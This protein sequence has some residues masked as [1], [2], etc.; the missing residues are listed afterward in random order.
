MQDLAA[1]RRHLERARE[2][3]LA[4]GIAA[5]PAEEIGQVHEG[6]NEP[7]VEPE[8]GPELRFRV[9]RLAEPGVEGRQV[10]VRLGPLRVDQLRLDQLG[11]GGLEARPALG[12][13]GS[14]RPRQGPGRLDPHESPRIPEER[15][16]G[17]G[18]P[19][20]GERGHRRHRRGPDEGI[21]VLQG[22]LDRRER[23]GREGLGQEPALHPHDGVQLVQKPRVDTRHCGQLGGSGSPA[24]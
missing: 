11:E 19:V 9:D 24:Q 4:V 5:L 15:R 7:R 16:G 14:R 3:P 20:G 17:R 1:P 23:R 22:R 10:H 8:R 12:Q 21:G 18:A 6:G 13:E 2:E